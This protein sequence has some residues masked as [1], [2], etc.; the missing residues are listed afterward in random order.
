M[1]REFNHRSYGNKVNSTSKRIWRNNGIINEYECGKA[2]D[3]TLMC[4]CACFTVYVQV[5]AQWSLC[6]H[7]LMIL[8]S[9]EDRERRMRE[10]RRQEEIVTNLIFI[11]LTRVVDTMHWMLFTRMC[12][13]RKMYWWCVRQQAI[14]DEFHENINYKTYTKIDF[15][16]VRACVYFMFSSSS[17]SRTS[18]LGT[19][20]KIRYNKETERDSPSC[21]RFH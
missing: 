10:R 6:A 9:A 8:G 5:C 3:H 7:L 1:S 4:S 15:V 14:A 18:V 12:H 2:M 16:R 13:N 21:V 11:F 20:F 17:Y 19:D